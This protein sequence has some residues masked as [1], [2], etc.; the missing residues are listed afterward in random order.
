MLKADQCPEQRDSVDEGFRS[1]HGIENPAPVAA[2]AVRVSELLTEH[3]IVWIR[4]RDQL[5]D[6]FLSTA[7]GC[8]DWARIALAVDSQIGRLV[9]PHDEI[10]GLRGCVTREIKSGLKIIWRGGRH[11]CVHVLKSRRQAESN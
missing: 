2:A 4:L 6:Q 8:R 10:S 11:R 3:G 9:V 7:I 1:V 5:S